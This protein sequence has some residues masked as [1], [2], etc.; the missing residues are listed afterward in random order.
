MIIILALLL[1]TLWKTWKRPEH[2]K[3]WFWPLFVI[4]VIFIVVPQIWI[5][6]VVQIG[7]YWYKAGRVPPIDGAENSNPFN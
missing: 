6:V 4:G 5:I 3:A 2:R 7:V 1:F